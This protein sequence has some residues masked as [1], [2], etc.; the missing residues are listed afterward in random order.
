[1][2]DG[3]IL[4]LVGLMSF[5][6]MAQDADEND[7]EEAKKLE[8]VVITGSRI[9]RTEIEGPSP[10]VV[11]TREQIDRQGFTTVEGVL[12]SLSQA[13][14]VV[15]NEF[16]SAQ[17]G[18]FTANA[19]S[20]DLRDL[21]PGRLLVL[22]DGRRVTDYP[23]AYNGQSN[24]V[25]LSAIPLVAVER[26][27]VLSSGASAIY[28][29][30]AV[31]GVVN[32]ILRKDLG[33][34]LDMNI[35]AGSTQD[36][37]MSTSRFQGV[38]GFLGSHWNIT[39]ALQYQ[40]RQPLYAG[41]RD[42]MD[43]VQDNPSP[44][45]RINSRNAVEID[46]F[47]SQIGSATYVDPGDC[48]AFSGTTVEYS[49]RSDPVTGTRYYCGSP[50]WESELQIVNDREEINFYTA[51]SLE[52]GDR[53]E[54]YGSFNVFS[55]DAASD[56]AFK[57]YFNQT[58]F[59]LPNSNATGLSDAFGVP[60]A[61]AQ[62]Q[63][64]FTNSELGPPEG[65]TDKYNEDVI[66][67]SIGIRGE[68]FSPLWTYDVVFSHS[69][70]KMDGTQILIV[71]QAAQDYFFSNYDEN[72]PDPVTNLCAD[73][74]DFCYPIADINYANVYSAATPQ[75]WDALTDTSATSSD[76]SNSVIT[77][78]ISGDLLDMPA[79]PLGMAA[80]LE[81][82]TQDYQITLDPR[83]DPLGP[84]YFWGITGTGGGGDRDRLAAGVE[85]NIPLLNKLTMTAA[86][87]Y[88][89]Y[90]DVTNVDDA[91]TYNAGL[92]FRPVEK[93]L[94]RG[95]YATSFRAP[96][97][98]FVFAEPSG[99]YT[100]VVD[101]YLCQ[102][103]EPTVPISS[104]TYNPSNIFGAR[105]GNTLLEEEESDSY[106]LG[107]VIEPMESLSMSVDYW[108]IKL[109][110]L[111]IDN[112]LSRILEIEADCRLGRKDIN[113]G[114]CIDA[115]NRIIRNPADGS[116][117]SEQLV[118]VDTGPVNAASNNVAGIDANLNMRV[119]TNRAGDFGFDLGYS[120]NLTNDFKLFPEDELEDIR[121]D[122]TR[123]WRSTVR[124]SANWNFKDF[125][126]TLFGERFGSGL[127]ADNIRGVPGRDIGPRSIFNWTAGYRLMDGQA[128]VSLIVN[129]LF[130]THPPR[131][132]TNTA[133]PYFDPLS[134]GNFAIGRSIYGQFQ[135]RF[136]Y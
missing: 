51:A 1:M 36:G 106:T 48:D 57:Y 5:N 86:M 9:A 2:A 107:F 97:M 130:D 17:F 29:S 88:D 129:N 114:E 84:G 26:I 132:E 131:D 46:I 91:I 12:K 95:S 61:Y 125:S 112:P 70:Y 52:L 81:W 13:N 4:I 37:G 74:F 111:V 93:L 105:V 68:F 40:N 53:H 104:C 28:G 126:T 31:A 123:G 39:Y 32:I 66:D 127:S 55:L 73:P 49:Q 21:G 80:V 121:T 64:I 41:Q 85:F 18:G 78:V 3:V 79:G 62:V 63:R 128:S 14:G 77:A 133:W 35:L 110:K 120:H 54:L 134:Y 27:E 108:N 71:E 15:Q 100:S 42:F 22:V 118:E 50:S 16:W 65:R 98:H 60:G 58:P 38:G 75:I 82:G 24:I 122:G 69:Q 43:S 10:V 116:L 117:I 113:S 101:E 136:D 89:K 23:L 11:I 109:K 45:G 34:S 6:A 25:N 135:Y 44:A 103:D 8:K 7:E 72:L 90:D 96:D 20:I 30:D 33:N 67:Y 56:T 59:Y 99:F 87:R 83:L 124:F 47:G 76:S 115:L 102:R 92:E 94:L 19:N 119:E